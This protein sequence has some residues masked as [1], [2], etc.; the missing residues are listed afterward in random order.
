[1]LIYWVVMFFMFSIFFDQ[2]LIDKINRLNTEIDKIDNNKNSTDRF[3]SI[4]DIN[5]K[6][7][8]D[9]DRLLSILIEHRKYRFVIFQAFRV[10]PHFKI[11]IFN[12]QSM[13]QKFSLIVL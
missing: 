9:F 4:F 13:F 11:I 12:Y 6:I 2:K 10:L 8:I 3:P 5:R 7:V 1:M